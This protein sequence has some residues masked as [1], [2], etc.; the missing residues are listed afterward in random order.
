LSTTG[1]A[2]ETG[3]SKPRNDGRAQMPEKYGISASLSVDTAAGVSPPAAVRSL[4]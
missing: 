2:L 3:G 1:A 4:F